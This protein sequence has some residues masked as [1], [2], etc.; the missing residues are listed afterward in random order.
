MNNSDSTVKWCDSRGSSGKTVFVVVLVVLVVHVVVIVV[1][2]RTR[3]R[4]SE[5][6]RW[7]L[8]QL[9]A[10]LVVVIDGGDLP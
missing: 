1:V 4:Q 8:Y 6:G 5:R 10:D 2:S 9:W 7:W 3:Q